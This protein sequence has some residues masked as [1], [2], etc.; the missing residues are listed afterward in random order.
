MSIIHYLEETRPE[1]PLL[2]SDPIQRAQA[3]TIASM[4]ASGIQPLHNSSVLAGFPEEERTPR[5]A[6]A[7]IK[8]FKAI[9]KFLKNSSGKYCVGDHITLADVY[10]FGSCL[11][12]LRYNVNL[13][14]FGLIY[15]VF[16]NL[17]KIESFQQGAWYNQPDCPENLKPGNTN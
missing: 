6:N 3:R 15:K 1:R 8:G 12:S 7:I 5:A 14:E 17:E 16:Q 11:T 13:N 4:I 9:E 2:P 10:L